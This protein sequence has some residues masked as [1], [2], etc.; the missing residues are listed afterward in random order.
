MF[1]FRLTGAPFSMSS[2]ALRVRRVLMSSVTD[3]PPDG[4]N[5]RAVTHFQVCRFARRALQPSRLG[6]QVSADA[7]ERA[8]SAVEDAMKELAQAAET[9]PKA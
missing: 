3:G 8:V 4:Y 5:M 9:H 1:V 7:M 6:V 2:S